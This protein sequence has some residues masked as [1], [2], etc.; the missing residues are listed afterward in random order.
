MSAE[1]YADAVRAHLDYLGDLAELAHE[2]PMVLAGSGLTLAD[3]PALSFQQLWKRDHA[4]HRQGF[5]PDRRPGYVEFGCTVWAC[6]DCRKPE[7]DALA[8]T[9]DWATS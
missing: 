1:Q 6:Q 4:D 3:V 2:N 9:G 7:P 5:I 8:A